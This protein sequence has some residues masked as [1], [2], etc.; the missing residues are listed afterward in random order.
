MSSLLIAPTRLKKAA[1][2]FAP[3]APGIKDRNKR[4]DGIGVIR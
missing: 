3:P 4:I 1:G 2:V